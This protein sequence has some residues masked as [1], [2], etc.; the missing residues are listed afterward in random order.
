MTKDLKS[1]NV[2]QLPFENVNLPNFVNNFSGDNSNICSIDGTNVIR[3]PFGKK[4]SK[5]K[6]LKRIKI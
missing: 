6:D 3:V 2:K 5:K 4:F 1:G